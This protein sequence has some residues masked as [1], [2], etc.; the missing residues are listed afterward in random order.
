[1]RNIIELNIN[2][3]YKQIF[4]LSQYAFQ[5]NLTE[6]EEILKKDEAKRHIIYGCMENKKL[7]A[8]LHIIPLS[9]FIGGIKFPLGGISSVATWPE[10]RRK[11]MVDNLLRYAVKKMQEKG[12]LVS[13]L[14]PFSYSFYRKYGWEVSFAKKIHHIPITAFKKNLKS[15][16]WIQRGSDNVKTLNKIYDSYIKKNNLSGVIYRDT[17]WW[18]QR[19]LKKSPFVA[20]AYDNS[21]TPVGYIIYGIKNN[22]FYIHEII[23]LNNCGRNTLLNF[24]SNHDSMINN[25]VLNTGEKDD[26]H[27]MFKELLYDIKVNFSFM[28]RIIDVLGFLKRYPFIRKE[29]DITLKVSDSLLS[30]NNN[31]FEIKYRNG[32]EIKRLLLSSDA[33][34]VIHIDIQT[35]SMMLLG[36]RRPLE[37]F[38]LGLLEGEKNSIKELESIIPK[39]YTFLPEHF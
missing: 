2:E 19:I 1:M 30:D 3:Y 5:Y 36:Y 25:V 8:K 17:R 35:L 11:G 26:I 15:D 21:M 24:L 22:T 9:T 12:F 27:L 38:D 34:N 14:Y 32:F 10:F 31:Y 39:L 18:E 37:I 4:S 7:A 13:F 33:C 16:G 29:I 23:S 6:K 20:I 28:A